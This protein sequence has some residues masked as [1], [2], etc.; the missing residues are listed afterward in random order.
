[1]L[2]V[3][4]DSAR[5]EVWFV[6][7]DLLELLP[8]HV[9]DSIIGRLRTHQH[10]KIT[11][12]DADKRPREFRLEMIEKQ[13]RDAENADVKKNFKMLNTQRMVQINIDKMSK[14]KQNIPS[15]S[16]TRNNLV[17]SNK[18]SNIKLPTQ[19]LQQLNEDQRKFTTPSIRNNKR[20]LFKV[21]GNN[22]TNSKI[23]KMPSGA[24]NSQ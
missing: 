2:S 8:I 5:V 3:I 21:G 1:M 23:V 6:N 16:S 20:A 18:G 4:A 13:R 19:T 22:A 7:Q 15:G 10:V 14:P 11:K 9:Q 24:F 12:G 17:Y